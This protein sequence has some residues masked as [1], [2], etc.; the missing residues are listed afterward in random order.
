[1]FYTENPESLPQ[2]RDVL[3]PHADGYVSLVFDVC[4]CLSL[5]Y[6][7]LHQKHRVLAD[8]CDVLSPHLQIQCRGAGLV[9]ESPGD[10]WDR[11]EFSG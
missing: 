9:T 10:N 7:L 5:E 11:V 6:N 1:M 8:A 2:A 4:S 3:S